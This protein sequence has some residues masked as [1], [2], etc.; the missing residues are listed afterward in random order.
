[1]QPLADQTVP[2]SIL[3]SDGILLDLPA[4]ASNKPKKKWAPGAL[5]RKIKAERT[6]AGIPAS[7]SSRIAN[8]L[9]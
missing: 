8:E 5:P 9:G 1:M 2:G 7:N 6:G 3:H 4:P